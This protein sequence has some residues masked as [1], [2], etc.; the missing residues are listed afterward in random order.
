VKL[1]FKELKRR[2]YTTTSKGGSYMLNLEME[3]KRKESEL[4]RLKAEYEQ[5][6]NI[7]NP[8][9]RELNEYKIGDLVQILG[10]NVYSYAKVVENNKESNKIAITYSNK[11]SVIYSKDYSSIKLICPVEYIINY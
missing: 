7:W 3:I 10:N 6:I 2:G 8:L 11:D 1:Q 9:G 4:N 5:L